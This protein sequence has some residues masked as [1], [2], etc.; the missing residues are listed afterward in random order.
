MSAPSTIN[1]FVYG[2]L[3]RGMP[4]SP[5]LAGSRFLGHG[6]TGGALYDLGPYPALADGAGFVYG[7]LYA[8]DRDTLDEL[9]RIEGHRPDDPMASWYERRPLTVCAFADGST[10][11]AWGYVCRRDLGGARPI[12]G[13][14]YRRDRAERA[15]P[16]QWVLA[17]GSNLHS[18]RLLR[19]FGHRSVAFVE[20]GFLDGYELRFNKRAGDGVCANLAFRGAGHRCPVAAYRVSVE[21]LRR[22]DYY[23]GEPDHY[24][25]LGLPFDRADGGLAL[26]H[27]YL[28]APERL[29]DA[30]APDPAYLRH[31]RE[32]YRE[33]GFD[34]GLLPDL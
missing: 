1:V 12:P 7:E 30:G 22:L 26:G 25:R 8:V 11:T 9:D 3:L 29:T 4:N 34:A 6:R 21:D 20:T 33:H 32:G 19:R 27:V 28:A 10:V 18:A 13:G 5:A 14:D 24:A 2:T 16:L 31:L 15:G 23:E 17:Y